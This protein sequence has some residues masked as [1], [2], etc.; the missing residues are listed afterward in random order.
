MLYG[1][2]T[3]LQRTSTCNMAA[4][5]I[6]D[7]IVRSI[8][9]QDKL[10][11]G[12]KRMTAIVKVAKQISHIC[13]RYMT[14]KT[15]DMY[16]M[17]SQLKTSKHVLMMSRM[18]TKTVLK[19]R[20]IKTMANTGQIQPVVVTRIT[21]TKRMFYTYSEVSSPLHRSKIFTK[22]CVDHSD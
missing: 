13:T 19:A 9:D 11:R 15:D 21:K 20:T 1:S 10:K 22:V 7:K 14:A 8:G 4:M 5:N 17:K 3:R 16:A 2:T 18:K 12:K 6:R